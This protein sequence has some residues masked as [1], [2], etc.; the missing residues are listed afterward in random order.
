MLQEM[1]GTLRLQNGPRI[2]VVQWMK[3][4][5]EINEDE[6]RD[7]VL[8]AHNAFSIYKLVERHNERLW[9]RKQRCIA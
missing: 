4:T 3:K 2:M 1:L 9:K 8:S 5:E 7:R 6:H